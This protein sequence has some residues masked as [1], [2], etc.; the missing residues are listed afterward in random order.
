MS[1]RRIE[2]IKE[3]RRA[4][5]REKLKSEGCRSHSD[6]AV[7]TKAEV[8]LRRTSE[9]VALWNVDVV[10][11]RQ[12]NRENDRH[13]LSSVKSWPKQ[14]TPGDQRRRDSAKQASIDVVDKKPPPGRT[15]PV[16]TSPVKSSPTKTSP[17]KSSPV[18]SQPTRS[19]A[20]QAE[21]IVRKQDLSPPKR[22]RDRAA[23]FECR[24]Q[25]EQARPPPQRLARADLSSF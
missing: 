8:K 20:Q 23:M 9:D 2:K 19:P 25:K 6:E 12:V 11:L 14:T 17:L 15:S 22:I 10:P 13:Q 7:A 24:S 4:Q 18:K 5:L 3:E 16:K 21:T 1:R